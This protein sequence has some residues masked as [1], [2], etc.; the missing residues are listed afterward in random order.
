MHES[1]RQRP[2]LAATE[3]MIMAGVSDKS[4][5]RQAMMSRRTEHRADRKGVER[6]GI[7]RDHA[8][9]ELRRPQD[10]PLHGAVVITNCPVRLGTNCL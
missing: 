5:E 2:K 9:G 4:A 3:A 7:G 8:P 1:L 10:F 6:G